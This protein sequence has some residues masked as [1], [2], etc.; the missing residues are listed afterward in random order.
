MSGH[1][2]NLIQTAKSAKVRTGS[3]IYFGTL[4]S[5]CSSAALSLSLTCNADRQMSCLPACKVYYN[6]RQ[7]AL[8]HCTTALL[9][10]EVS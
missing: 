7:L 2:S 9:G 10:R 6:V 1:D 3:W 4:P 5:C 8:Q